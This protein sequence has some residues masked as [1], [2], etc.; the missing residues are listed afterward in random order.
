MPPSVLV[1]LN[2]AHL[3][4]ANDQG[5]DEEYF[6]RLYEWR[7]NLKTGAVKGK[8][9]TGKDVALEFPVIN[10]QFAGLHHSYAY[11]QVVHSTASLAG[12]SGTGTCQSTV[13]WNVIYHITYDN[14]MP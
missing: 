4:S 14:S 1:G 7:L 12:G 9:I 8:Y 6:S 13:T 2:Q 5:T 10:D 3:T 11:A